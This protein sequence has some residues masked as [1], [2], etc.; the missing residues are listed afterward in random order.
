VIDLLKRWNVVRDDEFEDEPYA[1]VSVSSRNEARPVFSF[2]VDPIPGWTDTVRLLLD[3][4]PFLKITPAEVM[5]VLHVA[6]F[7]GDEPWPGPSLEA[8]AIS[9]GCTERQVRGYCRVLEQRGLL[10]VHQL[11]PEDGSWPIDQYDFTRLI[12]AL[13]SEDLD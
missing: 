10:V 13:V 7:W 8:V 4:Y 11:H 1:D 9:M 5:F 3:R 12:D 2:D 6:R